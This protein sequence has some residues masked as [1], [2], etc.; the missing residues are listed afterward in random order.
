MAFR[1]IDQARTFFSSTGELLPGGYIEFYDATTTTP[2]NVYGNLALTVNNGD[3][4]ALDASGRPEHD[5]WGTGDYR[6][7]VYDADDV[8]QADVD[9]VID[10]TA[11]GLT[12]PEGDAGQFLTTDGE[13]GYSFVGIIQVPSMTGQANKFLKNDGTAA[14]WSTGPADGADPD[15]TLGSGIATI[16]DGG[17]S[18]LVLQYGSDSAAA[19]G[20]KATSKAVVFGTAFQATPK[21]FVVSTSGFVTAAGTVQPTESIISQSAAGFTAQFCTQTGE[22]N[23]DG[24]ITSPVTFGWFAIGTIAA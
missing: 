6:F 10:P 13:G 1:I 15:I 8:E 3:T 2:R 17:A 7:R 4:I 20:T 14:L 18:K 23:S 22:A 16:G 21:I 12:L 9:D 5:I 11:A 19:S 24:N